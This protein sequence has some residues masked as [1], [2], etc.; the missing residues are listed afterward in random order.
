[1]SVL[2]DIGF[3][4]NVRYV[5]FVNLLLAYFIP[6]LF[7][8]QHFSTLNCKILYFLI[9]IGKIKD[10]FKN[11]ELRAYFLIVL[12]SITVIIL[13]IIMTKY[14]SFKEVTG[15][16]F[17]SMFRHAYFQVA[18]II[19]TTGYSTTNYEYWPEI[20]KTVIF[21]LMLFGAMA[22][23]TG[24]GIKISRIVI[25]IKSI[26][27]KIRKLINPRYVAKTKY[28]GKIYFGEMTFYPWSGYVQF[29]PDE[30][31]FELGKKFVLHFAFFMLD[32]FCKNIKNLANS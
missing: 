14:N 18:S 28:E 17:E 12:C 29:F 13:S 22:G 19:T 6:Y 1:M 21:I 23:S 7:S 8:L 10:V 26:F 4:N 16:D 20:A 11:E 25:A 9:L 32:S 31:D 27:T 15:S 3:I 2:S 30:F 5:F 24:G